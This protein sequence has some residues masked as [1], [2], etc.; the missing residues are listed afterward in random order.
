M[1]FLIETISDP[2]RA[3]LGL[4]W[5]TLATIFIMYMFIIVIWFAVMQHAI[6]NKEHVMEEIEE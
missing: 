4:H 3:L 2:L 1:F 5:G 6:I